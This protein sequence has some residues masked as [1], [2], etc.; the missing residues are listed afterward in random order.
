M[1][2]RPARLLAVPVAAEEVADIAGEDFRAVGLP[3]E[4]RVL[5]GCQPWTGVRQAVGQDVDGVES[6][7]AEAERGFEGVVHVGSA[8]RLGGDHR[9][10]DAVGDLRIVVEPR[11]VAAQQVTDLV[12][13]E[14]DLVL[15]QGRQT[16]HHL[17]QRLADADPLVRV[18]RPL[19]DELHAAGHIDQEDDAPAG[20][21]DALEAVLV[22]G[23]RPVHLLG[24]RGAL[25]GEG[26]GIAGG[27]EQLLL[28][29]AGSGFE[30]ARPGLGQVCLGSVFLH[31]GLKLPGVG[32]GGGKLVGQVFRPLRRRLGLAFL[33]TQ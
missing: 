7:G 30:R 6:G 31:V 25:L 12:R 11:A 29:V 13:E 15:L 18:R 8:D 22:G 3:G 24:Q 19:V 17:G 5:F 14:D 27:L 23:L 2:A 33:L 1:Y 32:L 20:E 10:E 4:G 16:A 21:L 9:L 26:L 28:L